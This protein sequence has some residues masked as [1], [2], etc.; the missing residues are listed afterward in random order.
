MTLLFFISI[1]LCIASLGGLVW[2]LGPKLA[3]L[4][5]IDIEA[6]PHERNM[7]AKDRILYDRLKRRI[8]DWEHFV[9]FVTRPLADFFK[10][11]FQ[12]IGH[13]YKRLSDAREYQKK[14]WSRFSSTPSVESIDSADYQQRMS[15]AEK[16]FEDEKFGEAEMKY[17]E[18]ISKNKDGLT[19]YHGLIAVYS[20]QKEWGKARDV[21]EYLVKV[22]NGRLK[23]EDAD[24]SLLFDAAQNSAELAD[25]YC[26]LEQYDKAS[27]SIR[28]SLHWQPL[29]PKY[30]DAALE[31]AI[32]TQQRLK[33]EKYLEQLHDANPEN[34]KISEFEERIKQLKY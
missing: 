28:K 8:Q 18:L 2:L 10:Q 16:Y 30:L 26:K 34:M 20:A 24:G 23:K 4:S 21:A 29:N 3:T 9:S 22:Y 33:A 15:E 25:I 11:F 5:R 31:I 17:I 1:F 13:A 12:A 32:L 19:P 7:K 14:Q 27:L 6:I